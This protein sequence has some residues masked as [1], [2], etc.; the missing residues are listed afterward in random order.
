MKVH[1]AGAVTADRRQFCVRCGFL[2]VDYSRAPA[3]HAPNDPDP[4]PAF[5]AE[6]PVTVDGNMFIAGIQPKAE[7]CQAA[8]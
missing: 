1:D 2:L 6:G 3:I 8:G 7:L 5:W 4:S